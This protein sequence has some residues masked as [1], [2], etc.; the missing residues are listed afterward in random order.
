MS[1][2]PATPPPP[3]PRDWLDLYLDGLLSPGDRAA[4]ERAL[5]ADPALRAEL[6]LQGRFDAAIRASFT[7]DVPPAP[8]GEPASKATPHGPRPRLDW[9]R[10][11][12]A[13]AVL[14]VGAGGAWW[15]VTRTRRTL[16]SAY[17]DDVARGLKAVEP[18]TSAEELARYTRERLGAAVMI[19]VPEGLTLI[20]WDHTHRVFSDHTLTLFAR[21]HG[22]PLVLFLDRA[23]E[24]RDVPDSAS[25]C[26]VAKR[27]VGDVMIVELRTSGTPC[28]LARFSAPGR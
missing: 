27:I 7:V 5:R 25:G 12:A 16:A 19:N 6:E 14:A 4:F 15:Y 2:V 18:C 11:A 28:L 22:Q 10:A 1:L 21:Y 13:I 20:G 8:A 9:L 24:D 3:D 17:A 26:Q 23:S